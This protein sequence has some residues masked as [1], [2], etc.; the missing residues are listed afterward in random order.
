[1]R[2]SFFAGVPFFSLFFCFMCFIFFSCHVKETPH[3]AKKKLPT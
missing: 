3:E 1:V 2:H